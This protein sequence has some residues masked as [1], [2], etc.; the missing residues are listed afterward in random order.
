MNN[1][2]DI[3]LVKNYVNGTLSEEQRQQIEA[4]I[5][6]DPGYAHEFNQLKEIVESITLFHRGELKKKLQR[7]DEQKTASLP[8]RSN[9]RWWA[10]AASIVLI[11]VSG[12][13]LFFIDPSPQEV[14]EDF[15]RPYYNV[16]SS[17]ERSP[18][19]TELDAVG[20][21]EQGQYEKALEVFERQLTAEPDN[22]G[23]VFYQGLNFLALERSEE[24]IN[25]LEKV[26]NSSQIVLAEPAQWYL[27]LAYLQAGNLDQAKSVFSAIQNGTGTYQQKASEILQELP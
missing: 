16:L 19:Q 1:Q 8:A 6:G 12:Y 2:I 22:W 3:E 9:R 21:Y 13:L 7:E 27:G 23:L 18:D 14:Y 5:A 25:N 26:T 24:A 10:M 4:H 20:L 15:Y 11:A 17:G